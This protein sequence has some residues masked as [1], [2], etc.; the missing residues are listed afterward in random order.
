MP[1]L[2]VVTGASS[3]IGRRA[4]ARL[5]ATPGR[6]VVAIASPRAGTPGPSVPV[7]V[8]WLTLDLAQP[9]PAEIVA[10]LRRADRVLHFAWDRRGDAAGSIDVNRAMVDALLSAAAPRAVV[11]VSS[12]AGAPDAASAYGRHKHSLALHVRAAGGSV[13]VPGLVVG[14]PPEGPYAI[15]C[16]VVARLPVRLRL[17]GR[18]PQVYPITMDRLLDLIE[19]AADPTLSPGT[20]RGFDDPVPFGT[21]LAGIEARNP[22]T[23]LPVTLPAGLLLGAARTL[24]RLPLPTRALAD[25][26]LT[27]LQ[28]NDAHLAAAQ[29]LPATPGHVTVQRIAS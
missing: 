12:V 10:T 24:K 14:D 15:L 21:F 26:V 22:R 9:L 29:P 27:F 17:S 16:K 23:R 11:F 20:W 28:K 13:F 25:K 18:A 4:V 5:A 2:I 3:P 19:H 1:E 6:E 7:G 8:R